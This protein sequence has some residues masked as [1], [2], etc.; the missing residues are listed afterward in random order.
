MPPFTVCVT[1]SSIKCDNFV[2]IQIDSRNFA[3]TQKQDVEN[4]HIFVVIWLN[5]SRCYRSDNSVGVAHCWVCWFQASVRSINS[6]D[7]ISSSSLCYSILSLL[8]IYFQLHN[9][10]P[11]IKLLGKLIYTGLKTKTS[12]RYCIQI[13][14]IRLSN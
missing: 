8:I 2:R 12:S 7:Y 3:T 10:A 13:L 9:C 1:S 5:V 11:S 6:S 4:N 14:L